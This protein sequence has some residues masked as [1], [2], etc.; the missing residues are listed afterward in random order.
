MYLG[1]RTYSEP[2]GLGDN[3]MCGKQGPVEGT[4]AGALQGPRAMV[5]AILPKSQ[6]PWGVPAPLRYSALV[7]SHPVPLPLEEG[8]ELNNPTATL[9]DGQMDNGSIQ[10]DEWDTYSALGRTA[11]R[12]HGITYRARAPW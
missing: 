1:H 12:Y 2:K 7:C 11:E 4:E 9:R 6:F 8:D 5:R 10:G 3:S